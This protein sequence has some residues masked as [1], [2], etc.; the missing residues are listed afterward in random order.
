ML[1]DPLVVCQDYTTITQNAGNLVS[2][3]CSERASDHS[4]YRY[5]DTLFQD[6][7]IKT[8]HQ[9]G[10]SRNR[11]T[12]RYDVAGLLPNT[13]APAENVNFSQSVYVVMDVPFS[14]PVSPAAN[15]GLARKMCVTIGGFL[16]SVNSD[17]TFFARLVLLGET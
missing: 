15:A 13:L 11:F 8:A 2:F 5:T 10:K 17:P 12:M 6:H 4:T 14:G 1:A 7:V 3:P 9:Y 16:V